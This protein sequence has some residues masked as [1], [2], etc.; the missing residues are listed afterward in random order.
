MKRKLLKKDNLLEFLKTILA[1]T[2]LNKYCSNK[3][4]EGLV[5]ASLRGVD[6][7]GIQLLPHY[8]EAVEAGRINKNPTFN[9]EQ[10]TPT[11]AI[12]DAVHSMGFSAGTKAM[13]HCIELARKYGMGGVSVKNSTHGGMMANYTLMAAE[14]G[15]FGLAVTNTTP[16]LIPPNSKSPFLG[17]NPICY[18]VPL[19]DEEPLCF[20]A[21]TTQ[22]TGN[23]VKLHRRLNKR[24]PEGLAAD[25]DGNP[26]TNADIAENLYAFGD[27]KGFGISMLVDILCGALAGMPNSENVTEMYGEDISNKRYLGQFFMA[28]DISAFRNIQ[29]FTNDLQDEVERLRAL[30]NTGHPVMAPGDPEKKA[31]KERS[32]DGIPVDENLL[33]RFNSLAK[34][35][36]IYQ[37][38]TN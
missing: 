19:K 15:M 34:E 29:D 21:A 17:T 7:H 8:I 9:L 26:T 18:A 28:F 3:T 14:E 11:T 38:D 27:Y 31:C 37:L 2:G 25:K 4:A 32:R 22:I 5:A 20:D 36:E 12:L 10:K 24:L 16:R 13:E 30:P 35:Y 1:Q 33:N 6:S 23:K